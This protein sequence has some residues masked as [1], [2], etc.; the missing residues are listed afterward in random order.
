VSVLWTREQAARELGMSLAHFK[1]H[2]QPVLPAK[3]VGQRVY[4]RPADV[5]AFADRDLTVGGQSLDRA[6]RAVS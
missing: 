4:F 3:R 6:L 2:V 1:R 5:A